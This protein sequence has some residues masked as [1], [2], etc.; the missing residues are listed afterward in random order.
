MSAG[1]VGAC[2]DGGQSF[3]DGL[4]GL[5]GR[6]SSSPSTQSPSPTASAT[7]PGSSDKDSGRDSASGTDSGLATGAQVESGTAE[8]DS[9]DVD[10]TDVDSSD[11]DSSDVD[12][13]D[14][15]SS[16]VDSGEPARSTDG[17]SAPT[18][19]EA[20]PLVDACLHINS[21][22]QLEVEVRNECVC[23]NSLRCSVE[24]DGDQV[25]VG[26]V[27]EV[28]DIPCPPACYL[29]TAQ[30]GVELDAESGTFLY[31]TEEQSFTL[32]QLAELTPT[33]DAPYGV[34]LPGPSANPPSNGIPVTD[35]CKQVT[36][37][38]QGEALLEAEL[39]VDLVGAVE[40]ESLTTAAGC[41]ADECCNWLWGYYVV[42]CSEQPDDIIVLTEVGQPFGSLVA[43]ATGDDDFEA[44]EVTL[45]CQGMQCEPTCVPGD[46]ADFGTVTGELSLLAEGSSDWLNEPI[47]ARAEF[48][49]RSQT[50]L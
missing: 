49:I 26:A 24:V 45:G 14:V 18:T 16:D 30:C 39:N 27:I 37:L 12:S 9:T 1:L 15:D 32:E 50:G 41:G 2:V 17:S 46:V 4:D 10:S 48:R 38:E 34:C 43:P 3:D 8:P 44:T 29:D 31:G 11:V 25:R 20:V 47:S 36:L 40:L 6:G 28:L 19:L 7:E 22:G 42:R 21:Q 33:P 13:S 5:E 35:L 23:P